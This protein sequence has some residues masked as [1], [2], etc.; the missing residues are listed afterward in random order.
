MK[1]VFIPE[2]NFKIQEKVYKEQNDSLKIFKE[3]ISFINETKSINSKC[4]CIFLT[5]LVG[6]KSWFSLFNIMWVLLENKYGIC[7]RLV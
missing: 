3:N 4:R 2:Y 6:K 1:L 7:S 5:L